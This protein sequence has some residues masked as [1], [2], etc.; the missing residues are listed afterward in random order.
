MSQKKRVTALSTFLSLLI[1]ICVIFSG[2]INN[3]AG[4]T[5]TETNANSIT[6]LEQLNGKRIGCTSDAVYIDKVKEKIKNCTIVEYSTIADLIIALKSGRIDSYIIDEPMSYYQIRET[7]GMAVINELI[8][9]DRYGF[10]LNPDKTD[11]RDAVNTEINALKNQ[12][13]LEELHKKWIISQEVPSFDVSQ[14]WDKPNGT[15]KVGLA[16]DSVPF[17]YLQDNNIVGYDVELLYMIAEKLGYGLEITQYDFSSLIA[18]ISLD[19]EDI[20][21][22]CISYTPERA[23]SVLFTDSTYD[24]GT[25]AVVINETDSSAGFWNKLYSS[26]EKTFIRENRWKLIAEGFLVTIELSILT[27]IF[28]SLAGFVFSFLLRSKNILIR[29]ISNAI[30]T[31]IDTIPLLITLMVFYYIIF[32]KTTTSAITIGVIG[33]SLDFANT[34]AGILNTGIEGIEKGQTEAAEAMGYPRWK[35]FIKIIFPQAA[36]R[37][38]SQYT[39]SV[40]G[41]VKGTSIIGYITV[42]DLTKAGD[43]IRSHTYE[44]F[45]PLI[46]TAVI[47]FVFSK[48]I[49]SVLKAI[50]KKINPKHRKRVIKG[51][52]TND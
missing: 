38:F 45:F 52:K 34:V 19:N 49:V 21:I 26:F 22:G 51:V 35:A 3:S 17:A 11:L 33:L 12:G 37:M 13:V 15:L 40:I 1:L 30:S 41:M 9:T 4:N 36:I 39:G 23:E 44:A 43:I 7:G 25:V 16:V 29:K 31:V 20:A 14:P 50:S 24:S 28:G 48:L 8:T 10:I 32:A 47:Y 5:A 27:L 42:V 2:C 18:S 6:N 46:T